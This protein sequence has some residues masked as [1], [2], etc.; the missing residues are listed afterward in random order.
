MKKHLFLALV[1]LLGVNEMNSQISAARSAAVGST[2][3]VKGVVSNGP[4]LGIIRYLQDNTAG[5]AA[6]GSTLNAVAP[7]DSIT[8]T[9]V[10][11]QFSNLLELDPI[12]TFSV[13]ASGRPVPPPAII[14]P[15]N[16]NESK[17]GM[18]VGFENC[19]FAVTG[20]F[21]S[22]A[23]YTVT[24]GGQTFVMR[25]TSTASAIIGTPIPTGTVNIK[26]IASQFC[27]TPTV[28]CTNGYQLLV[29]TPSDITTS[30]IAGIEEIKMNATSLSVYP[31]PTSTSLHFNLGASE[32]VKSTVATD[33]FGRVV[34]TSKENT[35]SVDVN[36]LQNGIYILMVTTD[37]QNYQARFSVAK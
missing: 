34:Y 7:G 6:Y 21:G 2:V 31:N 12:S 26:G 19:T 9:G 15:A 18:V 1:S 16:F 35:T 14:T 25:V 5:I 29:R 36:N 4:E 33:I 3:T 10:V 13:L 23:N 27:S 20:N 30:P 24:T 17:E 37:K 32:T 11:K 22:N 8:V 28:G